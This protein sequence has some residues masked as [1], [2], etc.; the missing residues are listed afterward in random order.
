MRRDMT[1]IRK[2][3]EYVEEESDVGVILTVDP[4]DIDGT[5]T[6]NAIAFHVQ[7]CARSGLL[8]MYGGGPYIEGLTMYG[9]DYLDE[10]RINSP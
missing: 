1:L 6:E 10:L 4:S 5:Y 3:L 2:I 9:Y 7:L 8:E